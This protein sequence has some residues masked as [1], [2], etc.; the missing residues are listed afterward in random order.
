MLSAILML[1]CL[2]LLWL[3]LELHSGSLAHVYSSKRMIV[4]IALMLLL[5][6]LLSMS[7]KKQALASEQEV[8]VPLEAQS[9]TETLTIQEL[10]LFTKCFKVRLD[11][12]AKA[13]CE[14][15]QLHCTIQSGIMK[16]KIS[17][18]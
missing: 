1:V 5:A 7:A 14:T 13:E 10:Y 4:W 8:F 9:E 3:A 16:F 18:C 17:W 2:P 11:P 15:E 12:V 6:V